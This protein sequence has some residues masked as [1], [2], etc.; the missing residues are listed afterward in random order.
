MSVTGIGYVNQN[1]ARVASSGIVSKPQERV[2]GV[3]WESILSFAFGFA[4]QIFPKWL[5]ASTA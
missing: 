4:T 2:L 3:E 1:K 5:A